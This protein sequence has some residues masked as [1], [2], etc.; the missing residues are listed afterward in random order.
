MVFIVEEIETP[1]YVALLA[2]LALLAPAMARTASRRQKGAEN[3][4]MNIYAFSEGW[5]PSGKSERL[6]SKRR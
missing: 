5:L 1:K 3:A 6:F 2:L 4:E